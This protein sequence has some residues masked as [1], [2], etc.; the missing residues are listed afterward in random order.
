MKMTKN[1]I[2]N[3]SI[4]ISLGLFLTIFF[5]NQQNFINKAKLDSKRKQ[6]IN[7]IFYFLTE[8]YY[9]KNQ[10]YPEF[11]KTEDLQNKLPLKDPQGRLINSA[12]SDYCYQTSDCVDN[13][14]QNFSL[15]AKLDLED[16]YQKSN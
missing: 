13:K 1:R 16:Y 5:T 14:C 8:D 3:L 12:N 4:I 9:Q 2:I 7:L 10:Y 11:I 6:D 15:S